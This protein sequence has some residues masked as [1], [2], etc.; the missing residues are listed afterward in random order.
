VLD[1]RDI[2]TVVCPNADLKLYVT[3]SATERARRRQREL[4]AAGEP[5]DFAA[6]LG[7]IERRDARDTSRGTAPLRIAPDAVVLDTTDLDADGAFRAALAI[8][9]ART[10]RT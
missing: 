1:G 3:A 7:D 4:E 8:V 6:V 5:A 10:V 2:G 9:E